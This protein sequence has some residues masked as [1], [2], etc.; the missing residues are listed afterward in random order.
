MKRELSPAYLALFLLLGCIVFRLL[1]S[2]FPQV[3]PNISPLMAISLVGAIYLPKRWGW[4]VGPITLLMTDLAFF[5]VN[6]LTVGK[7]YSWWTAASLAVYA[8]AGVLGILIA[9]RKSLPRILAGSVACSLLFYLA[10]N[11][12]SWWT[13]F[14]LTPSQ[15]YAAT[16]N[17]WL[18]ANTVGLPGFVPTWTFLRNGI[19]GDLFFTIVLLLLLDRSLLWGR[20]SIR[21]SSQAT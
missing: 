19:A 10:A 9:R 8:V 16:W 2:L 7:T 3:I 13:S 20:F 1:S 15:Q 14:A 12:F 18:Q 21:T 17:G 5:E 6:H 4:L 11:T